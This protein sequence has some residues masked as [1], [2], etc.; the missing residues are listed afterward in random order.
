MAVTKPSSPTDVAD[1]QRRM[2]QIRH[3]MHQ[4]VQGAV[5]GAQTL[6]DWRSLVRSHPRLALSVAAAVGYFVVPKRP[7]ETPTV[8]ALAAPGPEI[9]AKA[10]SG[11]KDDRARFTGWTVL[12]TALSLLAPIAVRAAQNYALT[13]FEQWLANHP[14]APTGGKEHDGPGRP[15][16]EPVRSSGPSARL[17]E[18]R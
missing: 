6:T 1:I 7:K 4:E 17:R 9:P 5:R 15:V 14:L 8:V 10:G 2:A 13:Y 18:F 12:G 16:S 11:N 3:E